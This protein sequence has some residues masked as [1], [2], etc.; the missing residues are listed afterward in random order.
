MDQDEL[1]IV[2]I[3]L[4]TKGRFLT[5]GLPDDLTDE[6]AK[7]GLRIMANILRNVAA[8]PVHPMEPTPE[9]K[10]ATSAGSKAASSAPSS[11][12]SSSESS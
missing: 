1:E 9:M 6:E 11:S 5:L 2:K 7:R 4:G 12:A 10:A 8:A 3:P